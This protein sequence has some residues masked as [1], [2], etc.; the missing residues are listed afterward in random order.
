MPQNYADRFGWDELAGNV[1]RVYRSL[2]PAEQAKA[3]I[4]A[5]NY[6][7]AGAIDVLGKPY[8]LPPAL[9]GHQNYYLWGTHGYTGEIVIVVDDDRGDLDRLCN[10]VE[11]AGPANRNRYAMPYENSKNIYICRGLKTPLSELWPKV[12]EWL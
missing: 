9:S 10:S 5:Q 12:K 2:P 4:F 3:V 6:G 11:D 7:E 8:G 1:A